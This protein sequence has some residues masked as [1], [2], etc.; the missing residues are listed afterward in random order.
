[1]WKLWKSG[2]SKGATR[3]EIE[4]LTEQL[5]VMETRTKELEAEWAS[6]YQKFSK[7]LG[8]LTKSEAILRARTAEAQEAPQQPHVAVNNRTGYR[9]DMTRDE[10]ARLL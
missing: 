10:I 4:S 6:M 5:R 7:I 9:E 8:H 2:F 1:M 3:G